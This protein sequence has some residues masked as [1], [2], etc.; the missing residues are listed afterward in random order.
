MDKAKSLKS[1]GK[2]KMFWKQWLTRWSSGFSTWQHKVFISPTSFLATSCP[3]FYASV[4]N[5]KYQ[6]FST[7]QIVSCLPVP[8]LFF[9][10][11]LST[12]NHPFKQLS[13]RPHICTC[14]LC[15][16]RWCLCMLLTHR[17]MSSWGQGLF[18][19]YLYLQCKHSDY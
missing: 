13:G 2:K 12:P 10:P 6:W 11:V 16:S 17:I 9:S 7:L 14:A 19:S 1:V 5:T 3:A 8:L 4:T 18:C 15:R